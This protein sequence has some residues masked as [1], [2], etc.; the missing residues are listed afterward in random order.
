ML[1]IFSSTFSSFIFVEN[2]QSTTDIE[3]L[4]ITGHGNSPVF[5]YPYR[6]NVSSP[7]K[8]F[9]KFSDEVA[10]VYNPY[11]AIAAGRPLRYTSYTRNNVAVV[12]SDG[13]QCAGIALDTIPSQG[14]GYM[15]YAGIL[16]LSTVGVS[17]INT[18]D[19]VGVASWS[20]AK[21]TD[22]TEF[23]RAIQNSVIKFL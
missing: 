20:V 17:G 9:A 19:K 8:I 6:P 22:G 14:I 3:E 2:Y 23:A 15:K 7:K 13:T 1:V 5:V 11:D 21:V 18:G 12:Q 16:D 10:M 4:N